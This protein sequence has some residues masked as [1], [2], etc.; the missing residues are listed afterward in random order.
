MEEDKIVSHQQTQHMSFSSFDELRQ[1]VSGFDIDFRPLRHNKSQNSPPETMF[2]CNEGSRLL[3]HTH[4]HCHVEQRGN[5][6]TGI[7]ALALPVNQNTG[8]QSWFGQEVAADSLLLFPDHG[9]IDCISKPGFEVF[10]LSLPESELLAY[11]EYMGIP[12]PDKWI[13]GAERI[14]RCDPKARENLLSTLKNFQRFSINQQVGHDEAGHDITGQPLL[15][16]DMVLEKILDMM[17]TPAAVSMKIPPK[18]MLRCIKRLREFIEAHKR[19]PLQ[20]KDLCKVADVSERTLQ[21]VFKH[22]YDVSPKQFIKSQRLYGL[23]QDLRIADPAVSRV[24]ILA[25]Y[26]GY[27]HFGQLARDYRHLFGELPSETLNRP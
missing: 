20:V 10:V 22:Y 25:R 6:Q 23:H 27:W 15:L 3:S 5:V 19:E 11:A 17:V 14:I 13:D 18:T 2:Q 21:R 8:I 12:E 1:A 4:L 16:K 7:R 26:W 9:E 24:E